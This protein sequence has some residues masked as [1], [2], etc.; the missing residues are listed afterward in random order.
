MVTAVFAKG[1]YGTSRADSIGLVNAG[2]YLQE[3]YG[4]GVC[5][6]LYIWGIGLLAAGQSS[7]MTGTYAGQFIMGGFLNL[8]MKKCISSVSEDTLDVLNEWLNVLQGMQ[9]PFAIIPLLT[10]VSN[11][12]IM[13]AF[14]IGKLIEVRD[15]YLYILIYN[16]NCFV[17]AP[18]STMMILPMHSTVTC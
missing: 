17:N 8:R 13:G 12:K 15:Q 18:F 1:F 16:R 10:L 9:I 7:T 5:P 3:R 4:G 2:Q 14:K 6:L 11:E